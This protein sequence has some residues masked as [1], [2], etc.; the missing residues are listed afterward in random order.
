MAHGEESQLHRSGTRV[1]KGK[2]E[3][4][5][6]QVSNGPARMHTALHASPYPYFIRQWELDHQH[7]TGGRGYQHLIRGGTKIRQGVAVP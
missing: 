5:A 6:V 3:V 7:L 4:P 1:N 2:K